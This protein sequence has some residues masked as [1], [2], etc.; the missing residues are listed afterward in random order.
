MIKLLPSSLTA[1]EILKGETYD[2]SV[3]MW[4]IGVVCYILLTGCFPF[5][6]NNVS[7]L[8]RK[9]MAGVYIWPTKPVVSEAGICSR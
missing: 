3:D 5:W 9:I 7:A 6:S 2:N 4:S 1:P 8:Y